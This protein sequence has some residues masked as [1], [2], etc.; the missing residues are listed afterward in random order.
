[1]GITADSTFHS[2]PNA[3]AAWHVVCSQ[4]RSGNF[5]ATRLLATY[6]CS[7]DIQL[8][9][10]ESYPAYLE[11]ETDSPL[12]GPLLICFAPQYAHSLH[13]AS[14]AFAAGNPRRRFDCDRRC[15]IRIR[16]TRN[17]SHSVRCALRYQH[18]LRFFSPSF[19]SIL[20]IRLQSSTLV[21]RR[22][23]ASGGSFRPRYSA[24]LARLSGG[25]VDCGPLSRPPPSP[26]LPCS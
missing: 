2:C 20:M 3:W 23:S 11:M 5:S 9:S 7:T 14:N 13:T 17:H 26:H 6:K 19:E 18:Q 21:R 12:G 24:A 10:T 25:V 16:A 8:Y 4:P 22:I 1:M 15:T